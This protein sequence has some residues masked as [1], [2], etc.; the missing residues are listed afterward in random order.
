M[1]LFELDSVEDLICRGY[2]S[3]EILE[4]KQVDT[5]YNNNKFKT[6]LKSIDRTEY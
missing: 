4:L 3:T 2:K 6:I 5:G 1:K